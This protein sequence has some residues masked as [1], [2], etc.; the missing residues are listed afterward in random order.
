MLL[1]SEQIEQVPIAD[2]KVRPGRRAAGD[3]GHLM[4]SIREI[5][6][7]NP[8]IIGPDGTLFAGRNRLESCRALGWATIP[9]R[10]AAL[11][12]LHARLVE[13]DENLIRDELTVL[14]HSERIV[15]RKRI[16]E[17]LHPEAKPE[18]QR[19]KGL[20]VSAEMISALT[21]TPAFADDTAAKTGVTPRT[22]RH[23]VQIAT[24]LAP[25]V[26]EQIRETPLADS[27]TE[28]LK[29]AR[30]PEAQQRQV[31]MRIADRPRETVRAAERHITINAAAEAIRQEPPPLPTGPFRVIVLDP[32]WQYQKRAEDPTHRARCPYPMMS[33]DEIKALPVP[34]LAGEDCIL[35]LWTTNAHMPDAFG[36]LDAWGFTHKTI[37]TWAKD[38]MGTGDWLRGQT[39]HCILAVKGR[40][41]VQLTNQT[42]LLPSPLREHSRKPEEFYALVEALCPGSKLELFARRE[43]AGWVSHGNETSRFPGD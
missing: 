41:V 22:V 33:T 2:V 5:G 25:D 21:A 27:K 10:R 29:L 4:E 36:I 18:E 38:R 37:L 30:M 39:E 20:N 15:E 32:P 12:D 8:I 42:T 19:K 11:D 3:L 43:R 31:A 6:L 1:P 9:A 13:I 17:T 24:K 35:W 14:A 34:A 40:P 7:L 26:K 23:E 16:Y 28:L